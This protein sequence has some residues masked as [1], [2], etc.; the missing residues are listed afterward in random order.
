MNDGYVPRATGIVRYARGATSFTR[1]DRREMHEYPSYKASQRHSVRARPLHHIHIHI[2]IPIHAHHLSYQALVPKRR[3]LLMLIH[4]SLFSRFYPYPHPKKKKVKKARKEGKKKER[5][6][7]HLLIQIII[8]IAAVN[9][10]STNFERIHHLFPSP[11]PFF[12]SLPSPS[13]NKPTSQKPST[14]APS[15]TPPNSYSSPPSL[16]PPRHQPYFS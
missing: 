11:P 2:H 6:N 5:I 1:V 15:S 14:S 9:P 10:Q 3:S 13:I 7:P 12:L 8:M 4:A 16:L